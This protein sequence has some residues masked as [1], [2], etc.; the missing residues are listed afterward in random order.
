LREAA[1]PMQ[2]GLEGEIKQQNWKN[3]ATNAGNLSELY[4]TLGDVAQAVTFGRQSVE[5]ADK[6]GDDYEKEVDLT[7]LANSL[8][9]DGKLQESYNI[10]K[11]SEQML[12]KRES[13]TE[14]RYS[15]SGFQFC[16]LLISQG[17]VEEVL[18][19]ANDT[20]KIAIENHW[21]LDIALDQLSLGRAYLLQ[22]VEQ[23]DSTF[24]VES[25][26]AKAADYLNQ[27]VD[28]LRK[29]GAQEFIA[30]GL[31]ARAELYRLQGNYPNA[32]E[33]LEEAYDIAERGEMR[34]WLTDYHLG[35]SRLL[36]SEF[37]FRNVDH[38]NLVRP[39][40]TFHEMSLQNETSL[41]GADNHL[42]QAAELV[43][44]TGYHRRDPELLLLQAQLHFANGEK[45]NARIWLNKAK[46]RFDEMGIRMWDFELRE[47]ENKLSG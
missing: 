23:M 1:Q 25:I 13:G 37:G 7:V 33:Y 35:A 29:A 12:K 41:R 44:E 16:D 22:A 43:K 27:A 2:A 42:K 47:L 28:G 20:I 3:A 31:F 24:E 30:R 36:I 6:S 9:Q 40:E 19:R 17:Q 38:H 45:E 46:K 8:H 11:E 4:L 32:W 15:Q 5:F 10:F 21:L 34:L 26:Y 18:K 39:V 14:F